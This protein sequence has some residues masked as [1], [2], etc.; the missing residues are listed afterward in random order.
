MDCL[1]TYWLGLL[2]HSAA[3]AEIERQYEILAY[4]AWLYRESNPRVW[5]NLYEAVLTLG[6]E[7]ERLA[8]RSAV[9]AESNTSSDEILP[10]SRSGARELYRYGGPFGATA[11]TGS[12][13]NKLFAGRGLRKIGD[14]HD[15]S[16]ETNPNG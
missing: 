8:D 4:R 9:P 16:K 3:I 6:H 15:H 2:G 7:V 13:Q 14:W 1:D 10:Y 12:E 5:E 11:R